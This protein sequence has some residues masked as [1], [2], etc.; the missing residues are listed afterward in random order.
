MRLYSQFASWWPLVSHPDEYA[1]YANWYACQLT[2]YQDARTV[3]ELGSGGGNNA[4]YMK[5]RFAMTL[6][7]ISGEMLAVS[8]TTNPECEHV[9]GD[10]RTVR[11]GR[12]FDAVFIHDAISLMATVEDLKAVIDTCWSHCVPGGTALFVPDYFRESFAPSTSR[13]GRDVG[14]RSLRYLEWTHDDDPTDDQYG[15]DF[16]FLLRECGSSTRVVHDEYLCG[17]FSKETWREVCS[18]VGFSCRIVEREATDPVGAG[19]ILC[20]K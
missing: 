17:A 11:L 16:V 5:H 7:D 14:P 2:R 15:V 1:S 12:E 3:L 9:R 8:E 18:A 13:G 20:R 6:V 10:M 19:A 4:Y